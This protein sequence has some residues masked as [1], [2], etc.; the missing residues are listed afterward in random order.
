MRVF[1]PRRK[2]YTVFD[3]FTCRF[4]SQ[5][6]IFSRSLWETYKRDFA[7]YGILLLEKPDLFELLCSFLL[8]FMREFCFRLASVA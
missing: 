3:K 8:F 1:N 7:V 4:Y 6:R 5:I 2:H